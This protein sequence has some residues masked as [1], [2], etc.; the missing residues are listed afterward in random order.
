MTKPK[1]PRAIAARE[2]KLVKAVIRAEYNYS[3][4]NQLDIDEYIKRIEF[5]Y[6][7]AF[8]LGWERCEEA[9]NGN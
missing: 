4:N 6:K 3:N 7:T 2:W 8:V 9:L 5:H 1:T